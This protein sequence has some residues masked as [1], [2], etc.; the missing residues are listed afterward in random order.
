[1]SY[2]IK[3]GAGLRDQPAD[4]VATGL[5]QTGTVETEKA[6]SCYRNQKTLKN[7]EQT[8]KTPS[9]LMN[10]LDEARVRAHN[11]PPE[12]IKISGRTYDQ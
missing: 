12:P 10:V 3:Q 4:A 2:V 8:Q 11:A 9:L 1:M 7:G 5:F 6:V